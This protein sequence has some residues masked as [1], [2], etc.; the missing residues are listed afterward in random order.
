MDSEDKKSRGIGSAHTMTENAA[1]QGVKTTMESIQSGALGGKDFPPSKAL[2]VTSRS[3]LA[4]PGG[5]HLDQDFALKN[6]HW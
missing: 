3:T 1:L 2:V 4:A 6:V 5:A